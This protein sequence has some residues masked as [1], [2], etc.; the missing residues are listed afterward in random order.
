MAPAAILAAVTEIDHAL[1]PVIEV[2]MDDSGETPKL[3]SDLRRSR[4]ILFD[5]MRQ[6]LNPDQHPILA[7]ESPYL[8]GDFDADTSSSRR[9]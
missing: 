7:K 1:I 4:F 8:V 2:F 6:D 3:W 9:R 5:A